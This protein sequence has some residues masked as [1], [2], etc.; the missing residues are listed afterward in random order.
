[1]AGGVTMLVKRGK[2][3]DWYSMMAEFNK[4]K[5]FGKWN[6][7]K[8]VFTVYLK[9]KRINRLRKQGIIPHVSETDW[10]G[11]PFDYSINN[12]YSI[13]ALYK[14]VDATVKNWNPLFSI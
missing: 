9:E 5:Y 14:A 11:Y 8:W 13:D 2:N 12:D 4:H 6:F 1:M 7:I 3:P 10:I